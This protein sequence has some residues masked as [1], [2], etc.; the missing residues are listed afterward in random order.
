MTMRAVRGAIQLDHDER[1]HLLAGVR[2]LL[3]K[4]MDGNGIHP[5]DLVSVLFTA[6]PD[7]VSAFPA[8]A[9]RELGLRDVPLICARELD[10]AGAL[11]RTV[12]LLAHMETG[13]AREDVYHVYVGGAGSLREDLRGGTP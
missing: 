12:R 7:L 11:P 1:E 8:E 13:L 4:I 9:A 10:V 5:D 2:E 3:T 6:T